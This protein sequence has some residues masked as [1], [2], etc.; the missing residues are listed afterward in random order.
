MKS[1]LHTLAIGL[2][3]AVSLYGCSGSKSSGPVVTTLQVKWVFK[4]IEEGFDHKTKGILSI[5]NE[6]LHTTGVALQSKP[7]N[8]SVSVPKGKHTLKLMLLAEY[9]GKWEEHI[10]A[11]NYSI[12]CMVE[13]AFDFSS[14]AHTLE[15]VFDL[16][17]DTSFKFK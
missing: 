17:T 7:Q 2:L 3:M 14:A 10:K 4:G 13:Q 9:E 5:D 11:N 6:P 16:D 1:S 12:D 15:V 8:F